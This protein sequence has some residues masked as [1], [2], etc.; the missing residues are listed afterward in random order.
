MWAR[1]SH[2]THHYFWLLQVF[3]FDTISEKN[4]WSDPLFFAKLNCRL[5]RK[6]NK[7]SELVSA[8]RLWDKSITFNETYQ[9]ISEV[10]YGAKLQ[11]PGLQGEFQMSSQT[12]EF[13]LSSQKL[14]TVK[15]DPNEHC[16]ANSKAGRGVLSQSPWD[17]YSYLKPIEIMCYLWIAEAPLKKL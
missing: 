7:S 12:S 3:K 15:Q 1:L 16:Y 8:N 17:M 9:D 6:A 10:V 11:L 5:Y 4:F 13:F 14:E 2:Q